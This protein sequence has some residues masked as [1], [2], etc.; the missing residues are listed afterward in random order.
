MVNHLKYVSSNIG[1]HRKGVNEKC[2]AMIQKVAI[3]KINHTTSRT[4][5]YVCTIFVTLEHFDVIYFYQM[6]NKL[7]K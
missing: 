3:F 1:N 5:I 2:L 4:H 6:K 7:E